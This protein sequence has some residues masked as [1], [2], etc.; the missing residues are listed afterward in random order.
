MVFLVRSIA[1]Q[2]IG[3]PVD[4][5]PTELAE[6]ISAENGDP[7]RCRRLQQTMPT[8]GPSLPEKRM[9]CIYTYAKLTSDPTA[10]KLLLPSEYGLACISNLWPEVSGHVACGWNHTDLSI[11][12][13]RDNGGLLHQSKNC[14]D[15]KNN[16]KQFSACLSYFAEKAKQ[17]HQCAQI[18]DQSVRSFCETKM[19]AWEKY[20]EL[21]G[22]FYFGQSAS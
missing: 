5:P 2:L 12:E 19:G 6:Q 15:F 8:M 18:P 13:C 10:C 3:Y 1:L 4:I 16:Q 20:P 7:L 21:R 14:E 17:S 9:L 11:F 22:S